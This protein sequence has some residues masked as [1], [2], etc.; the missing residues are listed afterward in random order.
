[1][2]V[3]FSLYSCQGN[4]EGEPPI[5]PLRTTPDTIKEFIVKESSDF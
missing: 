3:P 1:L 2:R 5:P 4:S